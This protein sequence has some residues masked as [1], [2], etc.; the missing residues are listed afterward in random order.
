MRLFRK[1]GIVLDFSRFQM[2]ARHADP[3]EGFTILEV[4]LALSIALLVIAAAVPGLTGAWGGLKAG[5][6]F[7]AFDSMVREAHRRSVAE[8]RTYVIVWGKE[9]VV[10]LR[11]EQPSHHDEAKGVREFKMENGGRLALK[12]PAALMPKGVA[13]EAVWT[14]WT[15][16]FCEPAQVQCRASGEAWT[17]FYDPFTSEAEVRYD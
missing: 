10:R 4:C 11:P 1:N 2:A 13:P 17:A 8:G 12:L 6:R 7:D 3:R 16:G 14:F 15:D 9:G 5:R